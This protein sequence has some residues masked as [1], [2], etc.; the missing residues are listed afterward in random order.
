MNDDVR[1]GADGTVRV[2]SDTKEP[3][4]VMTLDEA[5]DR[6]EELG[7]DLVSI[8][9]Q[10][11]PPLCRLIEWS[12]LKFEKEKAEK[13][14]SVARREAKQDLKELKLRPSTDVHDYAVVVRKATKFLEGNDRVKL[15]V[16]MRGREQQFKEAAGELVARFAQD[17][18]SAGDPEGTPRLVGNRWELHVAPLKGAARRSKGEKTGRELRRERKEAKAALLAAGAGTGA[19]EELDGEGADDSTLEDYDVIEEGEGAVEA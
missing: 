19:G 15:V 1:P 8:N 14:A 4:G 2:V 3:L 13:A 17:V 18:A 7:V 10:A 5:L 11:D 16:Q 12:K 9:P 6:A